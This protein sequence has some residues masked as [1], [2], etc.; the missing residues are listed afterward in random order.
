MTD[1]TREIDDIDAIALLDEPVRR[2][3]YEWVVRQGRPIGR[4]EAAAGTG[5]SRPLA[6]FHLDRLAKAGLLTTGFRRLS[7]K[8]GPG[9]GRP[10]KLYARTDRDI[11]VSL[12][13]RRYD[14]AAELMAEAL[15]DASG[16]GAS[17]SLRRAAHRLGEEVGSAAK[18]AAG[19][20]PTS[21]RSQAAL[22]ETLE[23]RGYEPVEAEGTLRLRNCPFHALVDDHRDLVCGMNLA[24]AEG[25]LDGLGEDRISA[26]LDRQPGLCCVA[27]DLE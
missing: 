8:S 23:E 16:V 17:T 11:R 21:A 5:V 13:E 14:I 25:M 7:G 15:E 19:P 26:H 9:A 10:S 4:D 20:R 12:P 6:A 3:L 27:F 22:V 18:V 1:P 2:T 24:L